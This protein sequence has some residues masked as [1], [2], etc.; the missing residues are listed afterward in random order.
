MSNENEK[1][2]QQP[3]KSDHGGAGWSG[4]SQPGYPVP[5]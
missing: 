4:G 1:V 3:G 5:G 2:Y